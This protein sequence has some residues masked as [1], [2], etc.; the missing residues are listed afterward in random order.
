MED[1][2]EYWDHQRPGLRKA[3]CAWAV[4]AVLGV[5][6]GLAGLVWPSEP[7]SISFTTTQADLAHRARRAF[8]RE[9][10]EDLEPSRPADDRHEDFF[11]RRAVAFGR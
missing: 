7:K 2:N 10:L 8:D 11:G 5:L 1:E 4:L 6:L 3:V 9:H